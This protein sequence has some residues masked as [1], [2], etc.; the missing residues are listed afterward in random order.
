[1]TRDRI[2]F[3]FCWNHIHLVGNY[4]NFP[5]RVRCTNDWL[6]NTNPPSIGKDSLYSMENPIHHVG[7]YQAPMQCHKPSK[8]MEDYD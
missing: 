6:S 7:R 8:V 5:I 1:M 2:Y 3:T 4:D